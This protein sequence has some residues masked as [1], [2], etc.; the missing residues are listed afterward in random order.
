MNRGMYNFATIRVEYFRDDTVSFE[1]FKTGAYDFVWEARARRWVNEYNFP[2]AKDGRVKKYLVT[3]GQ[4]MTPQ[5]FIFNLR[6]PMFQDR[7]VREAMN[8]AFDFESL[9]KT[10]FLEQYQRLRSYFQ[11][12][13]LEAKGMPSPEE[14]ALLEPLRDKV[15]PEVFAKEFT[16]PTTDGQGNV[17]LGWMYLYGTTVGMPIWSAI[18]F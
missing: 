2:A 1:A 12:S 8:L 7:R 6:K 18:D 10:L 4:P 15:P 16:Q 13:D 5:A 17:R 9:N 3:D 14:L 11:K